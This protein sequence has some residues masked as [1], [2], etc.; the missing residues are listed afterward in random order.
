LRA[1]PQVP[2]RH[3]PEFLL[4][5]NLKYVPDILVIATQETFPEKTEWEVSAGHGRSIVRSTSEVVVFFSAK[6]DRKKNYQQSRRFI[7]KFTKVQFRMEFFLILRLWFKDE[8]AFASHYYSPM[9][10]RVNVLKT[11]GKYNLVHA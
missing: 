7:Q 10:Q 11:G 9:I 4:P 3:L 1:P 8:P 5:S 6:A 2:P